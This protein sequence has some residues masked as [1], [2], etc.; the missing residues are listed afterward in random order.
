M[1]I[2]KRRATE[3]VGEGSVQVEFLD[4]ESMPGPKSQFFNC[5]QCYTAPLG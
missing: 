5:P 4:R 1:K 3:N 2:L